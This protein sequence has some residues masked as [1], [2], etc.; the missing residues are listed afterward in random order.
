M[1]LA[2]TLQFCKVA[3]ISI[4]DPQFRVTLFQRAAARE[5]SERCD[6]S[7]KADGLSRPSAASPVAYASLPICKAAENR[8][9]SGSSMLIDSPRACRSGN[10][11]CCYA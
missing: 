9:H 2:G 5:R 8:P 1:D 11:G 4:S 6:Q 10:P 3:N 7:E